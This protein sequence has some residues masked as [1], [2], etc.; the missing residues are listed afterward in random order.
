MVTTLNIELIY[1]LMLGL[2]S[3][4]FALGGTGKWALSNKLWRRLGVPVVIVAGFL[5]LG[6]W[7]VPAILTGVS[8]FGVLTLGYGDGKPWWYKTIVA[9]S[10][11]LVFL[12]VG[13]TWW[14]IIAPLYFLSLFYMSNTKLLQHDV[15]WKIVE[16]M[17]GAFIAATAIGSYQHYW[18]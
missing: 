12:L 6:C 14:F 10:Y 16:F 5:L 15:I 18:W 2:S 13:W 4:L 17:A 11:S 3:S 1:I 7:F 9:F 8:L